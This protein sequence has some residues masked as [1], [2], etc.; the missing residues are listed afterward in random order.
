VEVWAE[1]LGLEK[2]EISMDSN[3]FEIGG[4]SF[5]AVILAAK[6]QK[7]FDVSIPLQ[8]LF[9]LSTA[10][11]MSAY[12][13]KDTAEDTF[14]PIEPVEKKEFYPI[15]SAQKRLYIMYRM[16]EKNTRYNV[17][18]AVVLKGSLE[19]RRLRDTFKELI[20][21]HESLR[22]SFNTVRDEPV[23]QIHKIEQ[24]TFAVRCH[25]KGDLEAGEAV[26]QLIAPF[27]LGKAPLFRVGVVKQEERKHILVADMHHIVTDGTSRSILVNDFISLYNRKELPS[28][29][30]QYRDFSQWQNR[31]FETGEIKKQEQ[32]WL[33]R[34]EGEIPVMNNLTDYPRPPVYA[35]EGDGTN[36]IIEKE[37]SNKMREMAKKT[38]TTLYMILL[39]VYYILLSKY[40]D[41]EDIVIGTGIAGRRHADLEKIIGLFVNMLALRNCPLGSKTFDQF[42]L[43][44]KKNAL[45][46]YQSQ[47]YQFDQLVIKLG[48][49]RDSSRTPLF[50]TQFTFQNMNVEGRSEA[51]PGL[52][53]EPYEY[54]KKNM[55]FDLSLNGV[56]TEKL[57]I[58]TFSYITALF[59]R[60]TVEKLGKYYI[61]IIQQVVENKQITL[62]DIKVSHRLAPGKPGVGK[63]EE[64]LAF[65]F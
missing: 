58:L 49:S 63:K 65:G 24:V 44:V 62:K 61:E 3:F 27:D 11:E 18:S 30:L 42:L 56:E 19:I 15:S 9:E 39:A 4:Q 25:E 47:D 35:S 29:K 52:T 48:I 50:D 57:I 26:N 8:D 10:R 2:Q 14:I 60:T 36:F 53:L 37:L 45:D 22:T 1:V 59:K 5:K 28:L 21:R 31:L 32:Y 64:A 17:S 16:D 54:R 20:K 55:Q 43:E 13:A 33:A 7:E 38:G 41:E 46:A 23:Q 51:M 12:L 40:T 34:F 6:I